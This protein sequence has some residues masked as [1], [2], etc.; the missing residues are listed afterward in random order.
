MNKA[1]ENMRQVK[2]ALLLRGWNSVSAWAIAHG[3]L[4]VTARRAIYDWWHR[5][6]REPLGGINRQII[7]ELRAEVAKPELRRA[8]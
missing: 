8:A 6:D 7:A 1:L 4:P 5:T 3:F 2:A